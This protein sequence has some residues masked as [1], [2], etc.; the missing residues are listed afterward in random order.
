MN[1]KQTHRL[2]LIFLSALT[3]GTIKTEVQLLNVSYDQTREL[4]AE[5][6]KAF[7]SHWKSQTGEDVAIATSHGGS[8]SQSRLI[9][10]GGEADVALS[11]IHI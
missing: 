5:F 7:S 2:A 9:Q 3:L 11:L 4:Y 6:N 10:D 1:T 8:G